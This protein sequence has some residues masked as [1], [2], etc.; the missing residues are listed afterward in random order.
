MSLRYL[1]APILLSISLALRADV[2]AAQ[3]EEVEYLLRFVELTDC[4]IIRNGTRHDGGEAVAHIL[5]KYDYFRDRIDST[6]AFID[7]AA[8]RSTLSGRSYRVECPGKAPRPT[9]Q[10]LL[11]A[12]QAYR[13]QSR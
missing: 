5:K 13:E 10:W 7:Y 3:K 1:I 9:R 2:P 4:T 11:E 12:L 8:S 6:E